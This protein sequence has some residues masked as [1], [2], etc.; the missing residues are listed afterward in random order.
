MMED[1][2]TLDA[3][4]FGRYMAERFVAQEFDTAHVINALGPT[5]TQSA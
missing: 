1:Q 2:R 5:Q 3:L 4:A